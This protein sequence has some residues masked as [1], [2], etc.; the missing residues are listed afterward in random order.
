MRRSLAEVF[1]FL[2]RSA[3][4]LSEGVIWFEQLFGNIARALAPD[5]FMWLSDAIE[6][7]VDET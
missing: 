6:E 5:V 3:Y 2:S 1:A 4:Y 7:K